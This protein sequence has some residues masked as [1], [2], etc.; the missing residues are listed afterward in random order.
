MGRVVGFLSILAITA[1]CEGQIGPGFDAPTDAAVAAD[2]ATDAGTERRD[3]G[4]F[5]DAGLENAPP[6]AFAGPDKEAMVGSVVPLLGRASDDGRPDGVLTVLWQQDDGPGAVVFQDARTAT[7]TAVFDT[8]GRY[9][10]ALIASDGVATSSDT[11][12]ITIIEG[13]PDNQAPTV[14]AGGSVTVRLPDVAQLVGVVSDDG[15]PRGAVTV[16]WS[17]VSGPPGVVLG[18]PTQST[19]SAEFAEEGEYVLRLTADDGALS[20]SSDV[21][22]QVLPPVMINAAPSVDAGPSQSVV[23]P[24]GATLAGTVSDDGLPNG[25]LVVQWSAVN[26]PGNVLFADASSAA[27]TAM[28]TAAGTYTLRL[29]ADDGDLSASSQLTILVSSAP[30]SNLPP[31]VSAGA[32]QTVRLPASATLAGSA[33]DDGRP[34]PA[35]LSVSWSVV[36]GPGTVTFA[37]AARVDTTATFVTSGSYVLRLT[38]TD[39]ALSGSSDV[40]ITVLPRLN[41]PPSVNA[42]ASQAVTLPSGAMLQG[43]ATDDG[44]PAGTLTT[45]WSVVSGPGVV[46]FGDPFA[47]MTS[48]TFATAGTHVLRLTASDGALSASGDVTITVNPRPNQ[49]P[50][51]NA[52]PDQA[53]TLPAAA[54]ISGTASDDGLPA[55]STLSTT[56][57]R[58]SGPG[59]A[60]F[61]NANALATTVTFSTAGTHV[62]RLTAVDS[63]LSATDDLTVVVS[64]A[65]PTNQAPTANAGADQTITLPASASLLGSAS[66]DGLPSGSN[67]VTTWTMVSGPGTVAFQNANALSTTASFSVAGTYGLR[68][69]ASDSALSTSDD[70]TI[71]VDAAPPVQD[72]VLMFVAYND[73]WWPEYKVV[74]EALRASG[75]AVEVRSSRAGFARSDYS[76]DVDQTPSAQGLDPTYPNPVSYAQFTQQY[77]QN[78]GQAWN[79]A[80][81]ARANIPLAGRI[82]DVPNM[83]AYVALVMPGGRGQ[84]AYRYDGSY[85]SLEPVNQP[86]VHVST[87]AE[88]QAAALAI[89]QLVG[90]ALAA[91]KVVAAE[92]H[93]SPLVPFARVPG[94]TGGYGGLG[95]SVLDGRYA[96]GYPFFDGD[97]PARYGDLNVTLTSPERVV[98]D[99][100]RAPDFGGNGRD[101]IVTSTDWYPETAAYFARTVVNVLDTYPTP[102]ERTRPLQVLVFGGDEPTNYPP[103]VPAR[104]TDLAALLNDPSDDLAITAVTT[105]NPSNIT[106]QNLASYD[107]LVYFRHDAIAQ[108]AQNAVTAFADNGGGVVG[109]HHA[110][111]DHNSQ[112]GTLVQMFGAA[113]PANVL[114]NSELG[115]VYGGETN[116]LINVNYGHFVSTYGVHLLGG[117]SASTIPYAS[118]LGIPNENV[119]NDPTR[120][121]YAFTIP[122]DDELYPGAAFIGSASFGR[123]TNQLERLFSNDRFSAGSPNP[124]NGQYDTAGWVR[125]YDP[126]QDGTVGRVVYLQPGE[127]VVRTLAHPSF[128]QTIKNAVVWAA[129]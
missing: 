10:L 106:P 13:T 2:A 6:V 11:T 51:A 23:L 18:T 97:T 5:E 94:S 91:G 102:G 70:V 111:F 69:T 35:N 74:Y 89:N 116:R 76:S 53:I 78:F 7:T 110:I 99:G 12:T 124:N 14:D 34:A 52:G 54:S 27:T 88:V 37:D 112:K 129:N 38:A 55:G 107:V 42:G 63:A 24:G 40:G 59:S 73:V 20:T 19:T 22:V 96:T 3:A 61:G 105:N 83:N 44:L 125:R 119:D 43:T 80:W 100:P 30:P 118:S 122:A 84:V 33:T 120:G 46:A 28:F 75:Y 1:A 126:S 92:C 66:D 117:Q 108:S 72:T 128:A 56:W 101:L 57:S 62:L 4:A 65:A 39:G 85:A 113:L 115:V 93:G 9:T 104:H 67:L 81:N 21:R 82:Q 47:T 64:P 45:T 58:V 79:P 29:T 36:S 25:A 121:Y 95:R 127:T 17:V 60:T 71:T 87:A 103:Q 90:Q 48:A 15:L 31:S 26:G 114:L 50:T 41:Q 77:Q 32:S 86:G 49:P 68:L 123:G 109:L 98:V 16:V 8:V